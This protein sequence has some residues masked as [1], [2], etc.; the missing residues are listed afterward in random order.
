MPAFYKATDMKFVWC[1]TTILIACAIAAERSVAIEPT[2]RLRVLSYNIHH[3][4]GTDGK[5]D[6]ERIAKVVVAQQPDLVAL[7]EVD[8]QTKR[9]DR[10][11]QTAELAKLTGLNGR[12]AKQ[13][14][15]EGGE[16]GQAV[17][18]KYPIAALKVH[19]LPGQPER[20]QRIAGVATIMVNGV[21]INFATTHLH[22][23]R[24]DLR[25]EQ[26]IELNRLF[27]TTEHPSIAVGDMNAVPT[28]ATT[29]ELAKE[30]LLTR[31]EYDG[32]GKL[33]TFPAVKPTKQL[34]YIAAR[35]IATW[36]LVE[37]RVVDE[38]LAS[39]HR[40]LL[41]VLEFVPKDSQSDK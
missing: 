25:I 1:V 40:P 16:Y 15:F 12:F 35:P 9:T 33:W 11:D 17:L 36:R 28:E 37:A 5:V 32:V 41:A 29:A 2:F 27:Q 7:Q 34:D 19:V 31:G 3:G 24:S 13:I 8:N 20:E 14:D 6:L 4:E 18:S 23:A 38:E 39:D 21:E 30:W 26:A 10:V 22:H